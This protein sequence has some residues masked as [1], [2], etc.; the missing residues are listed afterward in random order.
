MQTAGLST[1][2]DLRAPAYKQSENFL[3]TGYGK[4]APQYRLDDEIE[5]T[6]EHHR[7]LRGVLE[8]LSASFDRPIRVLDA[9][10][11]TGRY[12]HCVRNT[13]ELVGLD[14]CPEMLVAARS[15]VLAHQVS[16]G[17]ISLLCANIFEISFPDGA[18]D[19]IYS[20]GMFA[21]GCPISP[22]ILQNFHRWLAPDGRFF[23]NVTDRSGIA[24]QKRLRRGIRS[25]FYRVGPQPVKKL[26]DARSSHPVNCALTRCE[27]A[28]LMRESAFDRFRI[29][30]QPCLSPLWH[31]RHLECLAWK[32]DLP[33]RS[34]RPRQNK[35]FRSLPVGF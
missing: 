13:A 17:K 23:F 11:G 7:H 4:Q 14:L 3:K 10:C 25:L 29:I 18:F 28:A 31:G 6:T 12:F 26:L 22:G 21:L 20:L 1:D 9:G 2:C 5:V 15:P 30:S 35:F 16:I 27:L 34:D 24:W 8:A 19:F 33:P 32:H